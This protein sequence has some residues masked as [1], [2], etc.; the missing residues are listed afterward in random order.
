MEQEIHPSEYGNNQETKRP[1]F[2]TVLCVLSFIALGFSIIGL[3][4]T[5]ANGKPSD[6][7]IET[8]YMQSQQMASEFRAKGT[9]WAADFIEQAA[10]LASHQQKNYW[11]TVGTNALITV[12]GF[13]GVLWMFKGKKLGFHL[14]II[15]NLLSVGASFLIV[16]AH[17]VQLPTVIMSLI[18]SGLFVYLYSKNLSWMK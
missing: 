15:Y 12:T 11:K 3:L 1:K 8:A 7:Q 14:Y 18:F 2:L 4:A 6:D 17:M 9:T 13:I 16:P 5:F 10:E